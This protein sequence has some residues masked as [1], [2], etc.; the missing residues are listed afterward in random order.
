MRSYS[1]ANTLFVGSEI[2][3][4]IFSSA[5]ISIALIVLKLRRFQ[6]TYKRAVK[7]T[8]CAQHVDDRY[9]IIVNPEYTY[10][11]NNSMVKRGDKSSIDEAVYRMSYLAKSRSK[12]YR[13]HYTKDYS[14]SRL[15]PL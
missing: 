4:I 13:D 6:R 15:S 7:G 1:S 2:C 5:P 8:S 11:K 9:N 12:G 14:S 10:N 3:Q